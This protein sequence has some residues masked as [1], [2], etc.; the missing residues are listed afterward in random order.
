[1]KVIITLFILFNLITL[2][3]QVNNKNIVGIWQKDTPEI[4]DGWLDNYQFFPDSSF[5]FNF[6]EF[7]G[8]KR[9][10]SLKGT[11]WLKKDTVYFKVK[12][13]IELVG[14]YFIR[15]NNASMHNTWAIAG[16]YEIKEITVIKPSIELTLI[17]NCPYVKSLKC[18]RIGGDIFYKLKSDP[19]DYK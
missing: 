13:T 8:S 7:D 1:M 12:S 15:D 5:C 18:I 4:A 17:E 16:N 11:Y 6:S 9:V 2:K 14:G 10:L 3:A 19:N